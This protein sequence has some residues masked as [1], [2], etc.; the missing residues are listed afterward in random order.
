MKLGEANRELLKWCWWFIFV[1]G[2]VLSQIWESLLIPWIAS[3]VAIPWVILKTKPTDASET[4]NSSSLKNS[5]IDGL[6][7]LGLTAIN[8][9]WILLAIFILGGIVGVLVFGW[10]QL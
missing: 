9:L 4:T 3:L 5:L 7:V 8:L 10:K 6:L 1:L 2:F